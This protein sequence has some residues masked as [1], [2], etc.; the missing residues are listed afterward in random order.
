MPN[1]WI[2]PIATRQVT[3]V[4]TMTTWWNVEASGTK[5]DDTCQNKE[6]S[7]RCW[8][9]LSLAGDGARWEMSILVRPMSS[10]GVRQVGE[11]NQG[12]KTEGPCG[13]EG[14]LF[15]RVRLSSHK[16]FFW[17][18][19][20]YGWRTLLLVCEVDLEQL[21][22][23]KF[24]LT[25]IISVQPSIDPTVIS[26]I[27]CK[28]TFR[29][30]ELSMRSNMMLLGID[31][32]WQLSAVP[33]IHRLTSVLLFHFLVLDLIK[34]FSFPFLFR[35]IQSE[36]SFWVF[37]VG[38]QNIDWDATITHQPPPQSSVGPNVF[39]L[40]LSHVKKR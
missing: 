19:C 24:W 10:L 18:V 14:S 7:L 39:S 1:R 17:G 28:P 26:A 2:A 21:Y 27:E 25:R 36:A 3:G 4:C 22:D 8:S 30:M 33:R 5:Q 37:A 13:C 23:W 31:S 40:L 20:W 6:I 29:N 34:I 16:F 11:P 9:R 32:A 15:C 12:V 38:V 35:S